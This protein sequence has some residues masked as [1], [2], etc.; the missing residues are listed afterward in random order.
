MYNSSHQFIVKVTVPILHV[1][2]E[3]IIVESKQQNL[4][5][6]QAF[7]VLTAAVG[8]LAL[9]LIPKGWK[10]PVVTVGVLPAHAQVSE[11]PT[12]APTAAPTAEPTAEPLCGG[13]MCAIATTTTMV[14][15]ELGME[16]GDFDFSMCTPNGYYI[17]DGSSGD[18]ATSSQDNI[19][20]DP[21][22]DNET[23]DIGT[24]V[25]GTYSI[26]LE[27][28][29]EVPLEIT[30]QIITDM[31][32]HTTTLTLTTDRAVAD[33]TF[34]GGNVT[35]RSDA[36]SPPCWGDKRSTDGKKRL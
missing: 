20:F 31:G 4:S 24:A 5:R 27:H 19:D 34:P 21:R 30:V 8:G 7:Q 23:L 12:V 3:P 36:I 13:D 18:G 22:V 25:P 11:A 16:Y 28:Y 10:T 35:W 14:G 26:Y 9:N 32:V 33:V 2:E 17:W 1:R 29:E 15:A 6:R